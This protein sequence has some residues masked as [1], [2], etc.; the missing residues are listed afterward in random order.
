MHYQ[1]GLNTPTLF[2][3]FQLVRKTTYSVQQL[4]VGHFGCF[5]DTNMHHQ[6]TPTNHPPLPNTKT[7]LPPHQLTGTLPVSHAPPS[8]RSPRV[9]SGQPL[10]FWTKSHPPAKGRKRYPH[11]KGRK[12]YPHA[13]GWKRYP[14]AKGWKRYPHAKG[15]KRYRAKGRRSHS[16]AKGR[17]RHRVKGEEKA[18]CS[19]VSPFPPGFQ[20]SPLVSI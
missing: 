17:K 14:H 2:Y 16:P 20:F 5:T 15:W 18:K 4:N 6:T 12:R 1:L 3:S 10:V 8:T 13:K 11:A 19:C 9:G 7:Q